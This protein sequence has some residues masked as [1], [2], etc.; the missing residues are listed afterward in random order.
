MTNPFPSDSKEET[1]YIGGLSILAG[2]LVPCLYSA[3]ILYKRRH[4]G[5]Q[6]SFVL[7]AIMQ[8]ARVSEPDS[9]SLRKESEEVESTAAP[10]VFLVHG[11]DDLTLERTARFIE[12]LGLETVIFREQPNRGRTIIEK[13]VDFKDVSFAVVLLTAD[14]K[15]G[16]A[17]LP[18]DEYSFRA[19]QNVIL[20]LGFF[21]GALGRANVCVLYVE[22]VEIPSDYSGVVFVQL[23]EG[24]GWKLALASELAA[25]GLPIDLKELFLAQER[26]P[27]RQRKAPN[28]GPQA[29]S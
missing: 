4:L 1:A 13:L 22:G 16:L 5:E 29:D 27:H 19:R 15:G 7:L 8:S 11:R 9:A 10:C 26:A 20:E 23:D 6:R 17:T 3:R 28:P 25:A 18:P 12:N 14:D 24:G 2:I 21:L